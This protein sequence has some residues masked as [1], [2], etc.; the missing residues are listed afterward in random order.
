MFKKK[1]SQVLSIFIA[2]NCQSSFDVGEVTNDAGHLMKNMKASTPRKI[3][4][5]NSTSEMRE[6]GVG[7]GSS[8]NPDDVAIAMGDFGPSRSGSR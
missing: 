4:S 6:S 7:A 2:A 1:F 5:H 3:R 8:D